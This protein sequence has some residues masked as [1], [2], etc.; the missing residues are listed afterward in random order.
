MLNATPARATNLATDG[1]QA[2]STHGLDLAPVLTQ[3]RAAYGHALTAGRTAQ[4]FDRDGKG[5]EE[6]GKLYA[7]LKA[8]IA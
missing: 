5:G 7:W 1:R 3:Q 4:E 2:V 8:L 6:I